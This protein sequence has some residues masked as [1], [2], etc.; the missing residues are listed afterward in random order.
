MLKNKV[1]VITGAS[2]GIGEATARLLATHQ[3]RLVLMARRESRLNTLAN[4]IRSKGS[5]A[6]II[7]LDITNRKAV[8]DAFEHIH[9]TW[10]QVDILI[11]NAGL[12]PVSYLDKLKIVEWERMIDVNLKGLLYC[13]AGVL[14]GMKARKSGHIVNI[15][16]AAGKKVWPGFAVYNATKFGVTALSEAM[17]MELTPSL[18]IKVSVVEP[19]AVATEL[20]NTITDQELLQDMSK[21]PFT[22][23]QADDIANAIFYAITQPDHVNVAEIFVMPAAQR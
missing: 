14:P 8:L 3:L 10:G 13:I 21:R 6:L 11:N 4:E 19:G 16:S 15:S 2:S 12:M 20:R 23:L 5:E 22:P 18:N 1:I 7:P 17:R 9:T